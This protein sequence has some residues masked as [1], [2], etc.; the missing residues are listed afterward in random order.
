MIGHV[1]E[2]LFNVG[3]SQAGKVPA[4]LTYRGRTNRRKWKE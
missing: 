4:P 3:L 1:T 2:A